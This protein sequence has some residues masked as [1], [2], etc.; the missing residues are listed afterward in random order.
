[1]KK[2]KEIGYNRKV[3]FDYAILEKFEVGIVLLGSEVISLCA[4]LKKRRYTL[5]PKNIYR[6][7]RIITP[8]KISKIF[9]KKIVRILPPLFSLKNCK[10]GPLQY[11]KTFAR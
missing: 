4:Q 6:K 8:Q 2:Y 10:G 7:S 11:K 1:M 9:R 3:I 5:V